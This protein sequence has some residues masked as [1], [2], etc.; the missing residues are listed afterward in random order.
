MVS[1][2]DGVATLNSELYAPHFSHPGPQ[3]KKPWMWAKDKSKPQCFGAF[4]LD[5][6]GYLSSAV[7]WLLNRLGK[8]E[9]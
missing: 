1:Q 8:V 6:P 5:G 2:Q 9:G 4:V 7:K 3:L